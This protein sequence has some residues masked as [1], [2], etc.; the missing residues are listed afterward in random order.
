[1]A[2]A[3]YQRKRRNVRAQVE[4]LAH[5]GYREQ[6]DHEELNLGEM[7]EHETD[8]NDDTGT[9]VN[10]NPK[11]MSTMILILTLALQTG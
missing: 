5:F 3:A 2:T 1:M 10:A 4:T 9:K 11:D 6:E 7:N 8:I